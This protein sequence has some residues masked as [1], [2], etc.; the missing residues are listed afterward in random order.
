MM[1]SFIY[2]FEDQLRVSTIT[3]LILRSAFHDIHF[4][5]LKFYS[6]ELITLEVN[7]VFR[8]Y[9]KDEIMYC[10]KF[11]NANFDFSLLS[12]SLSL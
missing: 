10:R 2:N 9:L 5:Y 3:R 1:E 6:K 11:Y 8:C 4:L 7:V 12:L